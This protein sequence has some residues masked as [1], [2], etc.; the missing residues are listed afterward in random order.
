MKHMIVQCTCILYI[1][2]CNA[3]PLYT[4]LLYSCNYIQSVECDMRTELA[5]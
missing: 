2:T 1:G 4:V 5:Y 3:M